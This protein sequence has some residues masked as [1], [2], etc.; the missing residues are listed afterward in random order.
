MRMRVF[1]SLNPQSCPSTALTGNEIRLGGLVRESH[2]SKMALDNL[3]V[4]KLKKVLYPDRWLITSTNYL[5]IVCQM[6]IQGVS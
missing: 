5:Y 1:T 6:L 2:E 4:D 3:A